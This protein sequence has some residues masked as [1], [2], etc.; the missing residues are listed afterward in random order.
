M[1]DE[2]K[3]NYVCFMFWKERIAITKV[4]LFIFY[5]IKMF[6]LREQIGLYY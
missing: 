6:L 4:S 2:R 1:V 5:I 3:K